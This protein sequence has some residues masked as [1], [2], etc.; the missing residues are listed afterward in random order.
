MGWPETLTPTATAFIRNTIDTAVV[1]LT[2]LQFCSNASIPFSLSNGSYRTGSNRFGLAERSPSTMRK[3]GCPASNS[4]EYTPIF[5]TD[6]TF[7]GAI[8]RRSMFSS[9]FSLAPIPEI[10]GMP[11]DISIAIANNA[12]AARVHLIGTPTAWT[13]SLGGG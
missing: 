12:S 9:T 3:P 10:P 2:R 4:S 13:N 8:W 1:R 5:C 7:C 11:A 6:S